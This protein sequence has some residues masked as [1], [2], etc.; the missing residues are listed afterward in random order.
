ML[1]SVDLAGIRASWRFPGSATLQAWLEQKPWLV[2]GGVCVI[3]TNDGPLSAKLI[4]SSIERAAH[5]VH[6]GNGALSVRELRCGGRAGTPRQALMQHFGLDCELSPF[7]AREIIGSQLADARQLIVLQ[8]DVPVSPDDWDAFIA[9]LELFRKASVPVPLAVAILDTRGAVTPEPICHFGTGYT[10]QRVLADG[11][12]TDDSIIWGRYLHLRAWWESGG[13][14]QYAS[15]LS[16][17]LEKIKVG[18]D[19][20]VELA[21][22]SHAEAHIRNLKAAVTVQTWM[23]QIVGC[24]RN[25]VSQ[26]AE[27]L[28][29]ALLGDGLMWRPPGL[30]RLHLVPA[31]ARTL[32]RQPAVLPDQILKLRPLLVCGPLGAEILELCLYFEARIRWRLAGR[33]DPAKLSLEIADRHRLFQQ[34]NDRFVDYPTG[35][36]APP[37]RTADIWV[38]ASLGEALYCCPKGAVSDLDRIVQNLRNCIA[39]GHYVAWS[40]CSHALRILRYLDTAG[41][42]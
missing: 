26:T 18:D 9:I 8:E 1:L 3:R 33:G 37:I 6:T 15:S 29:Q 11:A 2:E 34:G 24:G 4:F 7:R 35:H 13:S 32:L 17:I 10:D 19:V 20:A 30:E 25:A 28:E 31:A 41:S 16:G 36:P 12:N 40:H 23:A 42:L 27:S 39:H 38:F 21:L 5:A 22:Q 14:L